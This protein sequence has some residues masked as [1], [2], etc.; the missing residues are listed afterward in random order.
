MVAKEMTLRDWFAGMALQIMLNREIIINTV[1]DNKEDLA[2]LV[3]A[4]CKVCYG[5]ADAMIEARKNETSAP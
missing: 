1:D 2:T 5:L 3:G 4:S